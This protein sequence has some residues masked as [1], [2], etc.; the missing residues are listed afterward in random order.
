MYGV[1]VKLIS[2][3]QT[4]IFVACASF[5]PFLWREVLGKWEFREPLRI[6]EST[7]INGKCHQ[8]SFQKMFT[9]SKSTIET[10]EKGVKYVQ[11]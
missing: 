6:L 8:I 2:S 5:H 3:V 4:P 7:E 11:G 10:L 9:F 1:S